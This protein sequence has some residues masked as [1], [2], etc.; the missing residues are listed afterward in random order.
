MPNYIT[1]KSVDGLFRKITVINGQPY[2]QSSGKNSDSPEVWFPFLMVVGSKQIQL[3]H[4]SLAINYHCEQISKVFNNMTIGYVL[5][6][7]F[8]KD[9]APSNR[10]PTKETMI[11]SLQLGSPLNLMRKYRLLGD[12]NLKLTEDSI[13]LV[14][15]TNNAIISDP[16]DINNWLVQQGATFAKTVLT[17]SC[18]FPE[19]YVYFSAV[20]W[21]VPED[22]SNCYLLIVDEINRINGI[23][24]T[25]NQD[26]CYA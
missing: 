9:S 5:K 1:Y 2:Y 24:N 23:R 12:E 15:H 26:S 10:F 13:E 20:N 18:R 8:L 19:N 11:T 6:H 21:Y 17:N 22:Y 25:P 3:E 4:D 16:D 14:E 7:E